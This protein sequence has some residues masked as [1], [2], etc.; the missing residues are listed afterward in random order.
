MPGAGAGFFGVVCLGQFSPGRVADRHTDR[1]G[2][3]WGDVV[4]RVKVGD[5]ELRRARKEREVNVVVARLVGVNAGW[6]LRVSQ[7][8]LVI[9]G[10]VLSYK[11][12]V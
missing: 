2:R 3:I 12:S 4:A 1:R 7:V 11:A 6:K 8:G 5:G 10:R 9:G